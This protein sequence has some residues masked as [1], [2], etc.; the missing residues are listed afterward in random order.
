MLTSVI[1]VYYAN[2]R[3]QLL[4]FCNLI[5]FQ[6]TAVQLLFNLEYW[7]IVELLEFLISVHIIIGNGEINA[8][9]GECLSGTKK[10][11]NNKCQSTCLIIQH[12]SIVQLKCD[13]IV[14]ISCRKNCFLLIPPKSIQSSLMY[15]R[16]VQVSYQ[17]KI[18]CLSAKLKHVIILFPHHPNTSSLSKNFLSKNFWP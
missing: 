2:A 12:Y 9:Q 1:S 18:C 6:S 5:E 14:V 16:K 10:I 13:Q 17:R 7:I 4:M 15:F 3:N 8:V 11:S